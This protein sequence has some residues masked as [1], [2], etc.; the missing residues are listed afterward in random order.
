MSG[1]GMGKLHILTILLA[2]LLISQACFT[3]ALAGDSHMA[4]ELPGQWIFTLDA[5][6]REPWEEPVPV[7][8]AY[9]TL[10]ENGTMSL[11][12][13][14]REGEFVCSYEGTWSFYYIP[15]NNDHLTLLF[16]SRYD[17]EQGESEYTVKCIYEA[18]T[19]SWVENDT[20]YTYLILTED[21]LSDVSPFEAVYGDDGA[22]GVALERE[23]GPN[24]RIANCNEWVSLWE[25]RSSS[26]KRL[27]KVPLGAEVLAF[28][29][30]GDDNGFIACY[31]QDEYGYI[32]T[33]YL[34]PIE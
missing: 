26:S 4:E 17:P 25:K 3:A 6:D 5:Q 22:W 13:N 21:S 23:Q 20:L 33:Q 10:E 9:L 28:P 7:E 30:Y 34:E 29:E 8:L 12:C 15:E 2:V 31:Y 1:K 24:M 27:A 32:K 11:L 19:E 18:Y 14:D 16:T